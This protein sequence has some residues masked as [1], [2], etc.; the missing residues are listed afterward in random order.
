M[1]F[2]VHGRMQIRF[3]YR[4]DLSIFTY[5]HFPRFLHTL[6]VI[7]YRRGHV[8]FPVH[9]QHS[10]NCFHQLISSTELDA[11]TTQLSCVQRPSACPVDISDLTQL[12]GTAAAFQ[13]MAT[14]VPPAVLR[15]YE[16]QNEIARFAVVQGRIEVLFA[17]RAVQL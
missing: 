10:R 9:C 4:L 2:V 12:V 16:V 6:E 7:I 8:S 15:K 3:S 1:K 17:D 14:P 13:E 5:P 11:Q